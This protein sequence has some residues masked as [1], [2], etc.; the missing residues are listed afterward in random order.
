MATTYTLNLQNQTPSVW[1]FVVFLVLPNSAGLDSVAW[2]L[3]T[4][5]PSTGK[6]SISWT[7]DYCV[8]IATR[9]S[10]GGFTVF[11]DTQTQPA[12]ANTAW[13]I[14]D[15]SGVQEIV[16]NGTALTPDTI[17]LL[18]S[19]SSLANGGFGAAS[20]GAVFKGD[21]R[22]Q[23]SAVFVPQ[24]QYFVMLADSMQQGQV[25]T[26]GSRIAKATT[27]SIVGPVA[28]NLSPAAATKSVTAVVNGNTISIQ[29]VPP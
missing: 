9:G 28:L 14:V 11:S 18:N 6:G 27:S 2:Q 25:I 10:A 7:D 1:T 12:A 29:V 8:A 17:Q 3:R 21:L 22:G 20:L 23:E 13:K 5:P 16:A 4:L 24:P 19:T 15:S 26:R